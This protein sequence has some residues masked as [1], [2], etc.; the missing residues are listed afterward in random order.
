[1]ICPKCSKPFD[2]Y[3]I[4]LSSNYY[5]ES[6]TGTGRGWVDVTGGDIICTFLSMPRRMRKRRL[7]MTPHIHTHNHTQITKY[8]VI[9]SKEVKTV[10]TCQSSWSYLTVEAEW[11]P[12][13][14]NLFISIL[15]YMHGCWPW[16]DWDISPIYIFFSFFWGG[17]VGGLYN[18]PQ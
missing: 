4:L 10:C 8:D 1:M 12:Q 6:V 7:S 17:G 11:T 5:T 15:F 3:N 18:D 14:L 16:G 9:F 13:F 2:S